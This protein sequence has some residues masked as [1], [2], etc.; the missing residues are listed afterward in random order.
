MVKQSVKQYHLL[1]MLVIGFVAISSLSVASAAS[2]ATVI[3]KQ[4]NVTPTFTAEG[5]VEAI[6]SSAIAPQVSGSITALPVKVGD[7]VKAGQL[8]VRID[9]RMA[10]Q[11]V[12]TNQAQVAAAQAQLSVARKEFERKNRLYAKQY[13]SQAAMERAESEYKTAEA[14][15]KA[16]LAQT[17]MSNV[18]TGLHTINAPYSGV[19]AEV[20]TEVGGMAMPGQPM[21]TIYDPSRVRVTVNVPQS[22]LASLKGGA[23]VAVQ[24]PAAVEAERQVI[25]TQWTVLPTADAVSNMSMVRL[26]LPN[27][28][29][30]IRPGMFARALLPLVGV[31]ARGQIYVPAKAVVKRSELIAVYVVDKQGR[32][33]LRQVRLGRKQ[34]D[35][36]EVLAGL[37]A[38]ES[39]ALDPIA[40]ANI[41]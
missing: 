37:Q 7:I 39:V 8:L 34:G 27:Q 20:L 41:K 4:S 10:N 12:M 36:I 19:V 32:P 21:L 24:I 17:G 9:T 1:L 2:L 30:S 25:S 31:K 15:T 33:Q 6:K 5:V 40:A 11:Q 22:Q 26:I 3:I 35:H 28:L 13:I 14:Q 16:Q 38:G 23:Q 18:Q 29:S